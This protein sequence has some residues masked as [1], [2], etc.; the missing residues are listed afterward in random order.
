MQSLEK[1]YLCNLQKEALIW[2]PMA[3]KRQPRLHLFCCKI[4]FS[5]KCFQMQMI[6]GKMI[7]FFSVFGCILENTPENILQ[8]LTQCEVCVFG[9]WFT[10]K[11]NVNHFLN[12][13]KGFS[14]QRKLF[15]VWPP[16]YNGTNTRKSENIFRKIFYNETNGA[17][18]FWQ[19]TTCR[20][21]KYVIV[22]LAT[23]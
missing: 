5:T 2:P 6:S 16:F 17:L 11:L 1:R 15:S 4:F 18:V 10:K 21:H 3:T 22:T 20:P 19:K 14:G 8:C 12:F 23:N 9:K 7:F 13:N